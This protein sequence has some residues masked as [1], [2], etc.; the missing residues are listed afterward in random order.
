MPKNAKSIKI[1]FLDNKYLP[2]ASEEKL[3][4]S[5]I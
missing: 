3:G 4:G 1:C 5:D 2:P